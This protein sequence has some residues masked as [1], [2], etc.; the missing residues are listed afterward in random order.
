MKTVWLVLDR[1]EAALKKPYIRQNLV[2]E[3]DEDMVKYLLGA[4][5]AGEPQALMRDTGMVN[6]IVDDSRGIDLQAVRLEV[7]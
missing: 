2:F 4:G 1:S 3:K 7:R 5:F 6:F